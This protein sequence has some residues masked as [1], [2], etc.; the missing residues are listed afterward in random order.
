MP[1][2]KSERKAAAM[3]TSVEERRQ[4]KESREKSNESK[5]EEILN[6]SETVNNLQSAIQ[7]SESFDDLWNN[8]MVRSARAQ[9]TPEQIEN[10]ERLG[11]EMYGT[12]DFENITESKAQDDFD[13]LEYIEASL[14]SGLRPCDLDNDEKAFMES[15]YGETWYEQYGGYGCPLEGTS[16]E[17]IM[18][19]R[20][21]RE[22]SFLQHFGGERLNLINELKC[23][24]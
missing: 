14:R 6:D 3:G 21:K 2:K 16:I 17:D 15:Q 12:V 18:N 13:A 4:S 9:M 5:M 24:Q 23:K 8:P 19:A 22:E 7:S 1:S 20:K 11:R 10:Y